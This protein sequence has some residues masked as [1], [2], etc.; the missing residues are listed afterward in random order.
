MKLQLNATFSPGSPSRKCGDCQLCCKLLPITGGPKPYVENVVRE[1]VTHGLMTMAEAV[2]M[3]PDFR[4]PAGERCP[5][6]RHHKGCAIYRE[7][8]FGCRMW[9]CRWLV[10][11]DTG[12]MSRPDRAHYVIDT[13]PD[14]IVYNGRDIPV[15]LIWIDPKFPDCHRD[16]QLR[17]FVTRRGAEGWAAL[18]RLNA[19][20]GFVL[21]P[22]TLTSD[23]QWHEMTSRSTESEHSAADRFQAFG[24]IH[25]L[26]T[27]GEP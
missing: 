21:L 18:I 4:K 8:P 23:G 24:R 17:E 25:E 5:H 10:D 14:Y 11:D 20:D 16:P 22:P 19:R 12:D 2:A 27:Q 15:V 13:M 7:R 1:L 9:S 3:R 6:Q 26:M